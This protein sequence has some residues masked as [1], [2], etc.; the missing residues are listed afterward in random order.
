MNTQHVE[1]FEPVAEGDDP[2]GR[3][4]VNHYVEARIP[5]ISSENIKRGTWSSGTVDEQVAYLD[6]EGE[7]D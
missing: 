1:D 6:A 7:F 2:K 3:L 5:G 4:L